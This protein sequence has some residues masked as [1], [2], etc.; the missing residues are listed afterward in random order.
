MKQAYEDARI[1]CEEESDEDDNSG[2]EEN[3]EQFI[4]KIIEISFN[5]VLC[6]MYSLFIISFLKRYLTSKIYKF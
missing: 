1:E 6:I 3:S 2:T 5:F 4:S